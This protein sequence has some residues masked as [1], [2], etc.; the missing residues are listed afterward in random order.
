MKVKI[1]VK[2]VPFTMRGFLFAEILSAVHRI[3]FFGDYEW[4]H[5]T[6]SNFTQ[7]LQIFC[8]AFA[9]C[10]RE[11]YGAAMRTVYKI[12][13]TADSGRKQTIA[14]RWAEEHGGIW[15]ELCG[16]ND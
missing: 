5:F 2:G 15:Y 7:V 12:E 8:K 9:A 11:S 3:G 16:E 10:S 6:A 14:I 13:C 1:Y 4:L